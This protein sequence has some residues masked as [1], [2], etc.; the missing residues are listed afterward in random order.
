MDVLGDRSLR[1]SWLF[2]HFFFFF[3]WRGNG[4]K[5]VSSITCSTNL[6]RYPLDDGDQGGLCREGDLPSAPTSTF[7]P[8]PLRDGLGPLAPRIIVG[9]FLPPRR[10]AGRSLKAE[11]EAEEKGEAAIWVGVK[12]QS[13]TPLSREDQRPLWL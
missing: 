13:I 4:G 2:L 3:F 1:L 7:N 6:H 10:F 9:H 5:L 12:V 8:T 11:A